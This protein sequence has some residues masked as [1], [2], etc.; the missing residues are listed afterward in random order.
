MNVDETFCAF[1]ELFSLFP[2]DCDRF[3]VITTACVYSA[4]S[5]EGA[6][7]Y[8]VDDGALLGQRDGNVLFERR[9]FLLINSIIFG[10]RAE[11]DKECLEKA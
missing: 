7:A 11:G 1:C 2:R 5:Q 8:V 10:D 4:A 9:A 3:N 6:K